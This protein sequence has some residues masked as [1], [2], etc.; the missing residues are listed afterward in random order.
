MYFF[1]YDLGEV[2]AT[3]IQG[4]SEDL[5]AAVTAARTAY[6]SWS[7][8]PGHVR[9][10]HM[11]SI[12]RHVQKHMRLISV[13][14]SMDNGKPIRET[15]DYDVPI[16]VRHLYHHAGWAEL[17]D[18]EMSGINFLN[19]VYPPPPPTPCTFVPPLYCDGSDAMV[20]PTLSYNSI[21]LLILGVLT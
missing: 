18:T 11:Y 17:M 19:N 7:N 14:E 2:L 6:D 8:L 20:T 10:R 16:V 5:D 12:A 15:R 3:T 21:L 4:T 1:C 13:V 9:A